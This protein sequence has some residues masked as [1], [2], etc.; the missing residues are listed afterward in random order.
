V[1]AVEAEAPAP[2]APRKKTARKPRV[3]K[4]KK[5]IRE[6]RAPST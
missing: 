5:E 6:P 4:R 2:P 3:S 1:P